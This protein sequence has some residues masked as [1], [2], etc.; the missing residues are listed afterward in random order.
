MGYP[1]DSQTPPYKK[2]AAFVAARI[3][4][5]RI[6]RGAGKRTTPETGA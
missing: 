2:L 3:A 5:A 1:I 6:F 4:E